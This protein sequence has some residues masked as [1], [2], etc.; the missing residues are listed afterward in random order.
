MKNQKILISGSFG[1]IGSQLKYLISKENIITIGSKKNNRITFNFSNKKNKIPVIKNI[2]TFIH[3]ELRNETNFKKN[4]FLSFQENLNSINNAIEISKKNKINNFIYLSTIHLYNKNKKKIDEDSEIKIDNF[5]ELSHF[6][7]EEIIKLNF[8][9]SKYNY[10]I[11]RLSNIFGKPY[12]SFKRK[13]LVINDLLN[14]A[15]SNNQIIIN[16]NGNQ[17]RNFV[18][19]NTLL[20]SVFSIKKKNHTINLVGNSNISINKLALLIQKKVSKK[21]NKKITIIKHK[22]SLKDID[23]IKEY[24]SKFSTKE[25]YTLDQYLN[26]IITNI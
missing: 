25:T 12:N 17:I 7:N 26:D 10:K 13:T 21:L 9:K 20:K 4:S 19:S 11:F 5:Y 24:N 16:S 6:M 3:L 2:D 14:S 8:K 23:K 1:Y 22:N 18:S 15:L